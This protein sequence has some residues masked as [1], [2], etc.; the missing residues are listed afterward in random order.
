MARIALIKLFTGLNLAPAQLSG[1]LQR[2]GHDSRVIYF[3][4]Y[5]TRDLADIGSYRVTDHPGVMVLL[6]GKG[7]QK[8]IWNCY[9]DFSGQEYRLLVD[10]IRAFGADGIGFFVHSGIIKESAEVSARL[11]Q[12]L[13]LPIIWGG[14]GPTLEPEACIQH[15]DIVCV[16]EGE[17]VIVEFADRLQQGLPLDRIEGTWYRDAQGGVHRNPKPP[18]LALNDIAIPDWD[19]TRYVHINDDRISRNIYPPN[20]TGEYCIMTQRGCPFSCSFCIESKY[21]EMFGKKNS[22]RRRSPDLVIEELLWAKRNLDIKTVWF[23]DDVFTINPRWLDEFLPKY[24]TQI[25]LPFWCYTYPTTHTRESL[26][27]LHAAGCN[28]ITMGVQSGSQRIL[29]E[30]FNR[31]TD[32]RR[33]IEAAREIIDVGMVGSFDLITRNHV[34]T[35]EDLRATFDFLLEFP[36]EMTTWGYM[37]MMS[38]PTYAYTEAVDRMIAT[39]GTLPNSA[40]A[41][42]DYSY[43]HKLFHLTRTG[44]PRSEIRA[45]G[46]DP[47]YRENHELLNP[48]LRTGNMLE[49]RR[50]W[51]NLAPM[52]EEVLAG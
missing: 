17:E 6:T 46:N 41:D 32:I 19:T 15:A 44:L 11:R 14:A 28:S 5:I 37:E 9:Q 39:D 1:E 29:D 31:P 24:K 33:V 26:E 22:L 23:W 27:K 18:N 7:E 13:D 51:R 47:R 3:K 10:E 16:G 12:D 52:T 50:E 2:A 38:F 45:I 20:I 35:E 43:Y 25:G 36:Q 4:D 40:L 21:Q 49:K 8:K 48:F 30:H 42:D 34:D